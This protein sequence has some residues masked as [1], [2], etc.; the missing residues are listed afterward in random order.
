MGQPIRGLTPDRSTIR[1][2]SRPCASTQSKFPRCWCRGSAPSRSR[3]SK[4]RPAPLGPSPDRARPAL[5]E[6]QGCGQAAPEL[7]ERE[8]HHCGFR[9]LGCARLLRGLQ[10]GVKCPYVAALTRFL[11]LGDLDTML[12]SA[13]AADR[14]IASSTGL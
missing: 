6:G 5:A 7:T 13:M 4:Q 12:M 14:I 9:P 8:W 3:A 11:V 1:P 10:T 2:K